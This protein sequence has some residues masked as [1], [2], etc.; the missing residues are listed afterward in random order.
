MP[1]E[2]I[3]NTIVNPKYFLIKC[4][5]IYCHRPTTIT[6]QTTKKPQRKTTWRS[7]SEAVHLERSGASIG[8]QKGLFILITS[9]QLNP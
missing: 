2:K 4:K 1:L 7:G 3:T 8:C 9:N 6:T 5:S